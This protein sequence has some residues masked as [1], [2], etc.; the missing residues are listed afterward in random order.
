MLPTEFTKFFDLKPIGLFFLV[1]RCA[2][3]AA[4]AFRA[5]QRDDFSHS[6]LF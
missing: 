6:Y 2:V 1:P 3:I 5:L 4:L